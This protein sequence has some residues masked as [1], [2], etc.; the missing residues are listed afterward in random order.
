VAEGGRAPSSPSDARW[1]A[2]GLGEVRN[3]RSRTASLK[4]E[5]ER[6][7]AEDESAGEPEGEP[8]T[9]KAHNS[10]AEGIESPAS[11]EPGSTAASAPLAGLL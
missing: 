8:Y 6:R 11:E 1:S 3:P 7:P 10:L 5:D 4:V 9:E 2:P